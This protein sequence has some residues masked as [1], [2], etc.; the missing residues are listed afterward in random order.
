MVRVGKRWKKMEKEGKGGKKM[1]KDGKRGNNQVMKTVLRIVPLRCQ[2]NEVNLHR[3]SE[4]IG[5][6]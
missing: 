5:L 6:A 4:A 3:D 2:K 1:E